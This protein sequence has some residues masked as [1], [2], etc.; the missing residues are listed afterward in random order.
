MSQTFTITDTFGQTRRT[1]TF[2]VSDVEVVNPEG[3]T[4][5]EQLGV[6]INHLDT[7]WEWLGP[8]PPSPLDN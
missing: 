8:K 6:R 7:T 5:L 4:P 3:K 1:M 2:E